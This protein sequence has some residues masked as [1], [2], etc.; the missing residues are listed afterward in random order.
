MFTCLQLQKINNELENPPK[1]VIELERLLAQIAKKR[2]KLN[3]LMADTESGLGPLVAATI[4]TLC[5][6]LSFAT[7]ANFSVAMKVLSGSLSSF[8]VVILASLRMILKIVIL[9]Q[10]AH[11]GQR[12]VEEVK[13]QNLCPAVKYLSDFLGF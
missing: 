2:A 9:L 10:L 1:I 7:F 8:T 13:I 5:L 3:D 6:R 12:L 11:S 4:F